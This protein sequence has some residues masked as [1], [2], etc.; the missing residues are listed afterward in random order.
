LNRPAQNEQRNCYPSKDGKTLRFFIF[1]ARSFFWS[2]IIIRKSF[3]KFYFFLYDKIIL[4]SQ[5]D[6]KKIEFKYELENY[7]Y[8]GQTEN[9][10]N[11]KVIQRIYQWRSDLFSTTKL[12]AWFPLAVLFLWLVRFISLLDLEKRAN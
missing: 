11:L 1:E 3:G 2:L 9:T 10:K 7:N 8:I 6:G 12:A 4:L 5:A